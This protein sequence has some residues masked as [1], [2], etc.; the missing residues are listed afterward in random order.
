MIQWVYSSEIKNERDVYSTKNAQATVTI[1]ATTEDNIYSI[2]SDDSFGSGNSSC[3]DAQQAQC[4]ALPYE[5]AVFHNHNQAVDTQRPQQD[6][7]GSKLVSKSNTSDNNKHNQQYRENQ[8]DDHHVY[9]EVQHELK[10]EQSDSSV[11]VVS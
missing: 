10:E 8:H 9:D 4:H 2:V 3:M 1:Q 6:I 7:S 11:K 5:I